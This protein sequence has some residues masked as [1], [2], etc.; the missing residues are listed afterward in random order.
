MRDLDRFTKPYFE[1]KGEKEKGIY[2]V[3]RYKGD[4]PLPFKERFKS[5]KEARMFIYQ[6]AHDNPEWLNENGD[7]SELNVKDK[8]ENAKNRW[9][10]NAT[11]TAYSKYIDFKDW[12]K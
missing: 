5:L 1:T 6:Y 8:R 4:K 9:H 12:N 11:E 7:I 2:E 3:F 10:G